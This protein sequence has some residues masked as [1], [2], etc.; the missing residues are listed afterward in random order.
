MKTNPLHK[1][2]KKCNKKNLDLWS[3][4]NQLYF[5]VFNLIC[6]PVPF[7]EKKGRNGS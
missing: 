4:E 1:N 5:Y 6:G 7:C 2:T 3:G